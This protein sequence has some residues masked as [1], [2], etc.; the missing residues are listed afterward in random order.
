MNYWFKGTRQKIESIVQKYI[1]CILTERKTGKRESWLHPIPK[2]ECPFDTYH[3]NNLGP[4]PSI[5][6]EYHYLFIV[7]NAFTKFVWLYPTKS[8][9]TSKV[10]NKLMQQ[11]VIFGNPQ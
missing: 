7:I 6:K 11:S 3:I 10:I 4:L 1:N 8:T 2:E 5:K 9:G